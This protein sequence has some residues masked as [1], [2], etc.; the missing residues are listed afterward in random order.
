VNTHRDFEEFLR[1]LG[2]KG[3]EFVIVGGYAVSFHGYVRATNDMDLFF[4]ATEA[5]TRNILAALERFGFSVDASAARDFREP[6][7]IVRMGVSPIRIEL[8]NAISGR[9]FEE[10]WERRVEGTYGA[11]PVA[12]I[13]LEDLLANKRA[14]G[15]PRDLADIEE[16]GGNADP[17]AREP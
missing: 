16:L 13:S 6:G 5:N 14:A 10:V 2:E 17:Q 8:M 3:V 1:L 7:N 15:R 4:R 9:S 12:Y 11:V